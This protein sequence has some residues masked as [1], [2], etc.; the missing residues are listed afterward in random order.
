MTKRMDVIANNIAN[1]STP[2]YKREDLVFA[3]YMQSVATGQAAADEDVRRDYRVGNLTHTGN[4]L[5]IAVKDDS[6]FSVESNGGILY[7]RNG[8]FTVDSDGNLVTTSGDKVLD[9]NGQPIAILPT[10][11][12]IVVSP[13]GTVL[14]DGAPIAT[15]GMFRFDDPNVLERAGDGLYLDRNGAALPA[16]E[17]EL[18]QGAIEESNVVPVL[19]ITRMMDVMRSFQAAARVQDTE[20]ERLRRAIQVLTQVS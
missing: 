8:H 20:H 6:F 16:T 9:D 2:A 4:A 18:V 3:D 14:A 15:L 5:D 10:D 13:D 1:A 12:D 11:G 7:T 19:E 17:V